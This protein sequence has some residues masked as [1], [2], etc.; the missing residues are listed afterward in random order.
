MYSIYF[1]LITDTIQ[2]TSIND[3]NNNT[4]ETNTDI[5]IDNRGYESDN[6]DQSKDISAIF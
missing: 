3:S 5:S 1:T 4:A 2:L 6:E